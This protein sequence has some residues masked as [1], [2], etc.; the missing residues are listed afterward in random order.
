MSYGS[1]DSA[2]GQKQ[3]Q[4]PFGGAG[5]QHTQAGQIGPPCSN[6]RPTPA[7]QRATLSK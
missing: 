2:G 5:A 6:T 4:H 7:N 3:G 1:G